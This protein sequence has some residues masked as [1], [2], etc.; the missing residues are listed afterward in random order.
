VPAAL[1][2][3]TVRRVKQIPQ[4]ADERLTAQWDGRCLYCGR[5]FDEDRRRSVDHVPSKTLLQP[6]YPGN[7]PT[8][9]ACVECNSG[10]SD[11][12]EYVKVL[13]SCVLS[14]SADPSAQ[15]DAKARAALLRS[16]ELRIRIES[17]LREPSSEGGPVR[18]K[19]EHKRLATVL[20]KNARGHLWHE[21]ADR[22]PGEPTVAY[23]APR[24]AHV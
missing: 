17:A 3:G 18:W 21:H 5:G 8:V 22:R 4:Y 13:I 12:E 2:I 1:A 6:P 16:T 15:P 10:F 9:P 7:L 19:P 20:T 24:V 14:G 11:D 23:S